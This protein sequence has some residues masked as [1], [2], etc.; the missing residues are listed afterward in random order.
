MKVLL[1]E[2]GD[3]NL[4][5]KRGITA[6]IGATHKGQVEVVRILLKT[7]ADTR[8]KDNRGRTALAWAEAANHTHLM[9]LLRDR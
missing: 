9:H 1:D 4:R 6:L 3:L 5:T 2:G 8:I 7:G